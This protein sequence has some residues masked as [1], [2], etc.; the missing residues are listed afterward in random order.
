MRK[1]G[2]VL[3]MIC[4]MILPVAALAQLRVDDGMAA[5]D[6]GD[7][8]RALEI[9]IPL[10]E[11]GDSAA[12]YNLGVLALQGMDGLEQA[13]DW[14]AQAAG[15][16]HAAAQ[17]L[18]AD[19]LVD[20]QDWAGA[21]HWYEL[22]AMAGLLPA[23]FMLATLH[24]R[25]LIDTANPAEA[26]HWYEQAAGQGHLG[27]Q[28]ALGALLAEQGATAKAVL[29]FERAALQGDLRAQFNLARALAS[30][31]G[32]AQDLPAARGWY[33]RAARAGF[34]P[35][36]Y[37]LALMQARGQGGRQSFR[38]AYAWAL[39]ATASGHDSAEELLAMLSEAMAP[40]LRAQAEAQAAHCL[41]TEQDI[42]D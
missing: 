38:S 9:L 41:H 5:L 21:A 33:L 20:R 31:D 42:C 24:D 35:A 15:S 6:A 25:Q 3:G 29:W 30:G 14:L 16:G 37:N 26:A 28:F 22:A 2:T 27:A 8:A 32:V 4:I 7:S 34:A 12:Q 13:Q 23:Q 39:N 40:E 18:L 1:L 17:I 36:M 10:A 11:R 19:Q